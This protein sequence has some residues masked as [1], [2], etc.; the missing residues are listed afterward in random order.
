MVPTITWP[1]H[2]TLITGADPVAHGI[3]G[4][5]RPPGER[6]LDYAQIKVPTLIGAAHK[7]GIT[8]ATNHLA[9]HY[10]NA[11]VDWNLPEYFEKRRGGSMDLRSIERQVEARRTW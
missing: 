11:P 10:V 2:T 5:W 1:S 6:Y 3:L 7:A 4:N 8:T 9:R